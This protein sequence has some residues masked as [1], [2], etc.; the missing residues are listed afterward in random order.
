[1][2]W[3][4]DPQFF[5]DQLMYVQVKVEATLSVLGNAVVVICMDSTI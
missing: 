5:A 3:I 2:L 1:M 4:V